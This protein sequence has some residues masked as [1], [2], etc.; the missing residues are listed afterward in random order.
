MKY[1]TLKNLFIDVR[2][3]NEPLSSTL[4]IS[5]VDNFEEKIVWDALDN[6]ITVMVDSTTARIHGAL[7]SRYGVSECAGTGYER[8]YSGRPDK[9]TV[10]YNADEALSTATV[11]APLINY[12]SDALAN[13][14]ITATVKYVN[15]NVSYE[16]KYDIQIASDGTITAVKNG[17]GPTN[18]TFSV[19]DG[20]LKATEQANAM[21][22]VLEVENLDYY[23]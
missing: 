17:Q 8:I 4:D 19:A 2:L 3:P 10:I 20:C 7:K 13:H 14:R 18:V 23:L 16:D 6:D 21:N 11:I 5:L 12:D 22:F 1:L 15:S 9:Y